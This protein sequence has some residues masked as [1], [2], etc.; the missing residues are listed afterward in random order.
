V[1]TGAGV[2]GGLAGRYAT[3]LYD[4]ADEAKILDV[5]AGDLGAL[6]SLIAENK[7]LARLVDSPLV[8]RDAQAA[9]MEAMLAKAGVNDLT[10]RFVGV[11]TGNGRLKALPAIIAAYQAELARRRGEIAAE[12]ISARPLDESQKT[13]VAEAL[14][15]SAGGKVAV[16]VKVDPS[17]IGG[18]V[19]RV[20]SRMVDSSVRS[21]LQRLQLAM[22]GAQ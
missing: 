11:V 17:L 12:V 16:E 5:V 6:Q 22:K 9:A 19:V 8:R 18:L 1:A 2:I 10:R 13:T 4:L 3:A 7:D 15:A 20:G 14:R 21:K